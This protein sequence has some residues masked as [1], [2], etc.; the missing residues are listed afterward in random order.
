MRRLRLTSM[1]VTAVL[2]LGVSGTACTAP[3]GDALMTPVAA[4]TWLEGP[5]AQ[6]V[7]IDTRTPGE[8]AA[9]IIPGTDLLA[10]WNTG[11]AAFAR[12][13][14]GIAKDAPIV[15][16]CR[17]GNRSAKAA[18]W[19]RRNGYTNVRDLRGGLIAWLDARLPVI[20]P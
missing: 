9:G 18:A 4:K 1:L 3:E 16:Y 14:A 10:D 17:S 20:R 13:V 5:G 2:V 12:A 8:H 6:S 11:P 15:V 7:V 19:L